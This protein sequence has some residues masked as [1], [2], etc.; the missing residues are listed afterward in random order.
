MDLMAN[1]AMEHDAAK[2]GEVHR[3]RWATGLEGV[4]L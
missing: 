2:R 3:R 4:C 1:K